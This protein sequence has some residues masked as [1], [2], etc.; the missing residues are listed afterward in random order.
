MID[1]LW[2]TWDRN[3]EFARRLV[4]DVPDERMAYQ[5]AAGMNHPA[6]VLC[7]L[8]AYHPVIL[9]VLRGQPF[10]DPKDHPFGMRSAPVPYRDAYPSKEAL[11]RAFEGGHAEVVEAARTAPA[12]RLA[13][14]PP[15]ERW[16]DAMPNNAALL[17][18]LMVA[19]E[20]THLGQLS[21]WRRVQGMPPA[22]TVW[23]AQ[24]DAQNA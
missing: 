4:A 12:S 11:V 23:F 10:D 14:P 9:G 6:W 18:H 1:A 8:S 15:L 20:S 24:P 5:P 22:M 7:H 16:R 3:L 21:A 13:E 17:V 2:C 19:H